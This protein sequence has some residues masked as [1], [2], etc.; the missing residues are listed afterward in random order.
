M[1]LQGIPNSQ[2]LEIEE[3]L[4]TYTFWCWHIAEHINQWKEMNGIWSSEKHVLQLGPT[5]LQVECQLNSMRKES[6][7]HPTVQQQ[8]VST[9]KTMKL[10]TYLTNY[11]QTNLELTEYLKPTAKLKTVKVKHRIKHLFLRIRQLFFYLWQQKQK[12]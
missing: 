6:S 11:M 9:R 2:S 8:L 12:W 7:F 3:K 4:K 5:D 10:N 1:K